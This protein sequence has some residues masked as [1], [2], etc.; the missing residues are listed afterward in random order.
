MPNTVTVDPVLPGEELDLSGVAMPD[1]SRV[2]PAHP[3]VEPF[4]S[5]I[6]LMGCGVVS[7][8]QSVRPAVAA[9]INALAD[10]NN[11]RYDLGGYADALRTVLARCQ[12]ITDKENTE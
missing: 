8:D 7:P 11:D 3:Y 4:A 1:L 6:T 5:L 9:L 2:E 12:G 10:P